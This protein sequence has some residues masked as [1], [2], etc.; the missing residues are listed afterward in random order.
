M[1]TTFLIAAI[2]AICVAQN[3]DEYLVKF[4]KHYTPEERIRR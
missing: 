1:K 4:N 2:L 3:F